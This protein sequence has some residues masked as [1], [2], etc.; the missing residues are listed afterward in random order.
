MRECISAKLDP[1]P[2]A[3]RHP[4]PKGEGPLDK[5]PDFLCKL[6]FNVKPQ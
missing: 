5:I 6:S 2:V 1:S 3:S 4:L